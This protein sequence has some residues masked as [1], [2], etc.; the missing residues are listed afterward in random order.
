MLEV[1]ALKNEAM[2]I[3]FKERPQG[4]YKLSCDL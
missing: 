2:N 1:S 3:F 4:L